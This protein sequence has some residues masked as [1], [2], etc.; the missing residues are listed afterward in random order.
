MQHQIARAI[1][2]FEPRILLQSINIYQ[3]QGT[4]IAD[5]QYIVRQT[6]QPQ[7]LSVPIGIGGI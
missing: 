7:S 3:Q 6:Q 5:L 4:L 2:R 1:G